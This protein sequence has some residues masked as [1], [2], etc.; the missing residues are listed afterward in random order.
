MP[1]LDLK[2]G[3]T[4]AGV[5]VGIVTPCA[6]YVYSTATWRAEQQ[7]DH[8]ARVEDH[9]TL[10]KIKEESI[11]AVL[12]KA[13]ES[14]TAI[15]VIHEREAANQRELAALRADFTARM[16]EQSDMTKEVLQ[17]ARELI[18]ELKSRRQQEGRGD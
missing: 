3:I 15:K 9:S 11:Q 6:T 2:T 17:V 18:V 10:M 5:M 8:I 1:K 13:M 12:A 7:A 14:D 16:K 4:L